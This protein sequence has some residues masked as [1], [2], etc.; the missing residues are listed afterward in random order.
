[1]T[2]N[3]YEAI[4]EATLEDGSTAIYTLKPSETPVANASGFIMKDGAITHIL[5]RSAYAKKIGPQASFA[6]YV[7]DDVPLYAIPL[8]DY[9]IKDYVPG[10]KALFGE[11]AGPG[12]AGAPGIAHFGDSAV[13]RL[14]SFPKPDS[15]DD[16]SERY[17]KDANTE[18]ALVATWLAEKLVG[19]KQLKAVAAELGKGNAGVLEKLT[20]ASFDREIMP[21]T[22]A[23]AVGAKLQ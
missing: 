8:A 10:L 12:M 3:E 19:H 17:S 16:D 5:T 11:F 15:T 20:N 2:T 21:S 22:S 4:N 18:V 1:M 9:R 13:K 6:S 7:K 23:A 14:H